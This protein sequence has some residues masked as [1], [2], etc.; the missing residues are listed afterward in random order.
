M[1]VFE[2]Q[3]VVFD[4]DDATGK[5]LLRIPIETVMEKLQKG[6]SMINS[7]VYFSKEDVEQQ[8]F[9]K[10]SGV[11]FKIWLSM[12][13]EQTQSGK[14]SLNVY[15]KILKDLVSLT[16]KYGPS[17]LNDALL[18]CNTPKKCTTA[19]VKAILRNRNNDHKQVQHDDSKERGY[20]R[21]IGE[22]LKRFV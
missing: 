18:K 5:L 15:A 14:R 2:D 21:R 9:P 6:K 20:Q 17:Q 19:Y 12:N 8:Y 7:T 10:L 1:I 11:D 22:A 13:F 4:Y 3:E 16:E